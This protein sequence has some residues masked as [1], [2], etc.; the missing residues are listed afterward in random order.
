MIDKA[1]LK[2]IPK[3]YKKQI[4]SIQKG[5]KV[6]NEYTKRWNIMID[7]EWNDGETVSYQNASYMHFLLKEFGRN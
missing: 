1:L 2:Y 3:G 7:V 5:E 4:V 6:W